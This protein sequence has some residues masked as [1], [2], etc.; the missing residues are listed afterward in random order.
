MAK[1]IDKKAAILDAMLDL[2]VKRGFHD[3]PMSALARKSGASPGVIYHYFPSKDDLVRAVYQRVAAVKHEAF[4]QGYSHEMSARESLLHIW[5]NA[6]RFY[7][8]HRK[9][10]RFLDQYYLNSGYSKTK[11]AE[12]AEAADPTVK[13]IMKWIRPKK[14]GGVLK[15]L[16]PEA[17]DSLT[18]GLA[19]SLAKAPKAF[20]KDTLTQI[21][22]T[23][24]AAIA[25]E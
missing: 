4:F 19:A 1:K 5:L 15:D 25:Q 6:Y 3:A 12:D 7:R 18:L 23:V 24:W 11:D 13:R 8:T 10:A 16:P 17:I 20:S 22:E 14:H 9:E 21:A 2:M